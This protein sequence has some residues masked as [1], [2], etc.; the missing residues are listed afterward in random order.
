MSD[1]QTHFKGFAIIEM[2]GHQKVAGPDRQEHER[3][4]GRHGRG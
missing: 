4:K 1:Q 3:C 2:F